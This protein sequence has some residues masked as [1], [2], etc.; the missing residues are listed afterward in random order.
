MDGAKRSAELRARVDVSTGSLARPAFA[1][2]LFAAFAVA[3]GAGV[4]L[5]TLRGMVGAFLGNADPV[6]VARHTALLTSAFLIAPLVAG[7]AWGRRSDRYGRRPILIGGLVGFAVT[8]AATSMVSSLPA[9]YAARLLNGGFAAAVLPTTLALVADTTAADQ[10]RRARSFGGIS[11]AASLGLLA[12][13]VIG[14]L[15]PGWWNGPA[16]GEAVLSFGA[17]ALLIAAV[18][19]AMAALLVA[20]LIP[21]GPCRVAPRAGLGSKAAPLTPIEVGL[22]ALAAVAAGGLGAFEVGLTLRSGELTMTSST[23]GLM[24]AGC[25]LVMLVAQAIAFSPL[26]NPVT[27]R[28]LIAPAFALLA[29]GLGVIPI[30]G[31]L[32]A[33]VTATG[34]VAASGGVLAPL[35]AY[36]LSRV[37]GRGQGTELGLQ[38]AVAGLGQALGAAAPGFALA[39]RPGAM[40]WLAGVVMVAAAAASLTTLPRRLT[41]I[42]TATSAVGGGAQKPAGRT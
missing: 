31:G 25:M 4:V 2:L 21:P 42:A 39:G 3:L 9:L 6:A 1:A 38:T 33:L 7:P 16:P 11:V 8:I 23:L 19:S 36:W 20:R 37:S 27:T 35:L 24:F 5:P 22:L 28:L 32:P 40:L 41:A 18:P 29:L 15:S 14:G 13:P 10:R 12:G 34:L 30:A 17:V 26:V